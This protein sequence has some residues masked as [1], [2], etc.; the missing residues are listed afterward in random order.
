[1]SKINQDFLNYQI[2]H[3]FVYPNESLK[4]WINSENYL[5]T[6]K[7]NYDSLFDIINKIELL[8]SD[9]ESKRNFFNSTNHIVQIGGCLYVD[10]DPNGVYEEAISFLKML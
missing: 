10:T 3:N 6:Y 1:M 2:A 8:I 9:D 4:K 7:D 5:N